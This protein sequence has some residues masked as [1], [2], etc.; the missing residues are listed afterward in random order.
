MAKFFYAKECPYAD[1]CS[2]TNFK[3]WGC[4]GWTEESC[5]A[6][7]L[8]HLKNS[9]KHKEHVPA[10]E[11]RDTEYEMM[12]EGMELEEDVY[13]TSQDTHVSKRQRV[14]DKGKS[15]GRPSA[16]SADGDGD[17]HGVVGAVGAHPAG[18]SLAAICSGGL[19]QNMRRHG[20]AMGGSPITRQDL[21]EVSD[22]L[23]RCVSSARH[24]QRLS[25]MAA[26][27]FQEEATIFEEVKQFVD[28]K[29]QLST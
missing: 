4:W 10:G 29:I 12:V 14:D 5:R 23:G 15:K 2:A 6:Q 20:D 17:G 26:K 16:S 19:Q 8:K 3:S 11:S 21:C 24:A 1:E 18:R 7:V 9:G 27:A 22:A 28:A 13:D 25:A